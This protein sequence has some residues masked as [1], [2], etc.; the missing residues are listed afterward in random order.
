M[1]IA[2]ILSGYSLGEADMLRR[3]MGKKIREEMEKQRKRFVDGAVERD[4]KA[5][6]A[7]HIFDVLAKFADYGFNKSH[8]AAYALVSYQTAWLK[9]NHP[10]EF[11]AALM[12]LDMG[13]TDKLHDFYREGK[14]EEIEIVAPSVN[15]SDVEF[16]VRGGKIF[17]ALAAIKGVG[18]QAVSHIVDI[19]RA[20]G[21]FESLTN[22]F[23]RVDPKQLNRKMLENLIHAGAFDCF[24]HTR[25]QLVGGLDRLIG[26]ATRV[27]ENQAIGMTDMF[28]GDTGETAIALPDVAPWMSSEKLLREFQAVGFYLSAHP[29]DEYKQTLDKMRVQPWSEFQLAVK[30]GATAGNLAGTV[31]SL[32]QRKTRTGNRMGILQI[33]D[34][35]GQYEAVLF[36]ES[37]EQNK[38]QLVVGNAIV[39]N[40]AAE[41]KPE[42]ISLRINTVKNLEA[43]AAR[44]QFRL[45]IFVRDEK[46]LESI[47]QQ[48]GKR[49]EGQV[50]LI[51]INPEEKQEVEIGIPGKRL[52]SPA[53]AG[54][55]KGIPG[56]VDVELI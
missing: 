1:Q 3:A 12:T 43:E 10:V 35:T 56:V 31:T 51:V 16:A 21:P 6:Q 50:S 41:D 40:V 4:L 47:S 24:G 48:I 17:Y 11:L 14:R 25:E 45:N 2:Q 52:I 53:I 30:K 54:A 5:A 8:A 55:I 33:S 37:L 9:A 49:G 18:A 7:S 22:F 19:R 28:G 29:L 39:L 13:N 15:T 26:H 23:S 32:Q 42:G 38:D 36:S 46:P 20:E 34:P 44:K 27:A